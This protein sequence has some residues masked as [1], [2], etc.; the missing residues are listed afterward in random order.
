MFLP[1][2]NYL[3]IF[4]GLCDGDNYDASGA[5]RN[6]VPQRRAVFRPY[7]GTPIA[8][9]TDGTSNTMA[10]AEYL[11]GVDRQDARG[12]FYT[13][14][15]CS[16]FLYVTTGPNSTTPDNLLNNSGFCSPGSGHDLPEQDLPC[17]PR[18]H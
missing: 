3:G 1:K 16:Q 7:Q 17:V 4:A 14:R 18:R 8:D 5:F 6:V 10:V 12:D 11:K 15:A 2:S 13:S 9:I